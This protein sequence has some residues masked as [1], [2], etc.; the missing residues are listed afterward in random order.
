MSSMW[1]RK[2]ITGILYAAIENQ[3]VTQVRLMCS[4]QRDLLERCTKFAA[5]PRLYAQF[6]YRAAW[7]LYTPLQYAALYDSTGAVTSALLELGCDVN[8]LGAL[9][10][11]P[12]HVACVKG[13]VKVIE[14]LLN[15]RQYGCEPPDLDLKD[16]RGKTPRQVA[17][18]E[19]AAALFNNVIIDN[20]D[21]GE[22]DTEW[23]VVDFVGPK[24]NAE[25]PQGCTC[26][27]C[28]VGSRSSGEGSG[29]DDAA[30]DSEQPI[31]TQSNTMYSSV[32]ASDP[33]TSLKESPKPGP[34]KK[35]MSRLFGSIK[36]ESNEIKEIDEDSIVTFGLVE[37]DDLKIKREVAKGS[38]GTVYEAEW[39]SFRVAVKMIKDQE[40]IFESTG[41]QT[42]SE[43]LVQEIRLFQELKHDNIIT[44]IGACSQGSHFF[45]CTEFASDGS[46]YDFLHELKNQYSLSIARRWGIEVA[47]GMEYLASKSILHRDLKSPN[48]LLTNADLAG[49]VLRSRYGNRKQGPELALTAKICDFGLSHKN[50]GGCSKDTKGTYRWMAPEVIKSEE[51]TL[52]SDVYSYGVV[53]WELLTRSIPFDDLD[54]QQVLWAVAMLEERPHIPESFPAGF[55][56]IVQDC[57]ATVPE[58]RPLWRTIIECLHMCDVAHFHPKMGISVVR[59]E[60]AESSEAEPTVDTTESERE[61]GSQMLLQS[62][63]KWNSEISSVAKKIR[64]RFSVQGKSPDVVKFL[65]SVDSRRVGSTYADGPPHLSLLSIREAMKKSGGVESIV[66][67]GSLVPVEEGESGGS[68]NTPSI[69]IIPCRS[70]SAPES[71]DSTQ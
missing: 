56:E 50:T 8:N 41:K 16:A 46:L 32:E 6:G 45:L 37:F 15:A 57:F 24:S 3:D 7:W 39:H 43:A 33:E 36:Q 35:L 26:I 60:K 47:R 19:A 64:S 59:A 63:T 13:N 28:R 30:T 31:P 70:Q 58:D 53:L 5:A 44:F 9:Q 12:L 34:V 54:Q 21:L 68:N 69:S 42:Q 11:S 62:Q 29:A 40:L 23:E 22:K 49:S 2:D 66:R 48:I 25:H 14:V 17:K 51:I 61:C 18:G 65:N 71:Y 38:F 10:V 55:A 20:Q 1:S 27:G 4:R 67:R 52:K